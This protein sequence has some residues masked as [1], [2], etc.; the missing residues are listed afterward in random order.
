MAYEL[1]HTAEA[2]DYKLNLIEKNKNLLP[3][4]YKDSLN[5]VSLPTDLEDVGD[6]SILTSAR[7]EAQLEKEYFLTDCVLSAGKKYTVSLHITDIF[8]KL[9][10]N[11]GFALKVEI[12]N[13]YTTELMDSAELDLSA[14]TG[15]VT[16]TVLLVVPSTFDAG[17]LIK[18]QIEEGEEKTAWIPYMKNIGSYVDERFNSLNIRFNNVIK[19]NSIRVGS[20]TLDEKTLKKILAFIDTYVLD[21]EDT[22]NK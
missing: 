14:E 10:T 11:S 16:A 9:T 20:E 22:D 7:N 6:G 13:I 5:H 1:Q 8:D 12:P 21:T 4:P 3:Y 19:S 2:I 17:L 18:P 15:E